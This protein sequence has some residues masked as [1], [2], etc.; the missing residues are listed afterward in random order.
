M[1]S[2]LQSVKT[3]IQALAIENLKEV[4]HIRRHLHQHP[5][6]SFQ[7]IKT[8]QYIAQ[9]LKEYGIEFKIGYVKTGIVAIIK[10]KNPSKNI[11]ALRADMDA[12]P[13][14]EE[15]NVPYCSKNKGSMHAC[16]HDVHSASLLGTAKILHKLRNE[17]EGTVKLMFQP[18]EEV[19]P[20][21][22]AE[23]RS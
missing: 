10:G 22:G 6:L 14:T 1:P 5:E 12:L 7:E 16:G 13:I 3:K 8:S 23:L 18:G 17:F 2:A 11:I 20:G 19:L 21:S 4:I 9:K 15:N